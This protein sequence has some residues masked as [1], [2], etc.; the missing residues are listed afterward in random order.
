MKKN[1]LRFLTAAFFLFFTASLFAQNAES[2][3]KK[4]KVLFDEE[5]TDEAYLVLREA[6]DAFE[7]EDIEDM[8]YAQ[9]LVLLGRLEEKKGSLGRALKLYNKAFPIIGEKTGLDNEL[10]GDVLSALGGIY[11][12]VGNYKKALVMFRNA[13]ESYETVFDDSNSHMTELYQNLGHIYH[14]LGDMV[15][16][17]FYYKRAGIE[18]FGIREKTDGTGRIFRVIW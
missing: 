18:Y 12:T 10:A 15:R 4:G 3:Y 8:D 9:S 11:F 1:F 13:A 6:V 17:S 5:K 7:D 16:A 14:L 2:L